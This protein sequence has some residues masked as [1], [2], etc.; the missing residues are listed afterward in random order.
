VLARKPDFK[1]IS[2]QWEKVLFAGFN[3]LTTGEEKLIT[4]L[5]GQGIGEVYWMLTGITW[6]MKGRKPVTS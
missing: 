3:A 5:I 2:S 6:K 1:P 4:F